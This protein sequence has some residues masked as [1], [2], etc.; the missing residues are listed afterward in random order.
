[1]ILGIQWQTAVE[2]QPAAADGRH[3]QGREEATCCCCAAGKEKR[4]RSRSA[5]CRTTRKRSTLPAIAQPDDIAQLGL[6]VIDIEPQVRKGTAWTRRA[7]RWSAKVSPVQRGRRDQ[8]WRH[9][10]D[11]RQVDVKNAKHL[12]ELIDQAEINAPWRC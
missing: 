1:M 7:A 12:R 2:L 4:S 6:S 8:P 11:V 9:R 10:S 3:R 5:G